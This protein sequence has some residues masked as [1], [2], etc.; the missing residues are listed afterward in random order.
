[1]KKLLLGALLLIGCVKE[2]PAPPTACYKLEMCQVA[3]N[4]TTGHGWPVFNVFC[5]YGYDAQG[6]KNGEVQRFLSQDAISAWAQFHPE[7]KG[8]EQ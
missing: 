8:C 5:V 7:A 3:L 1:M 4:G 6:K 2:Q